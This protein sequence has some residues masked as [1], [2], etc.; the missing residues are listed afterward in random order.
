MGL[1]PPQIKAAEMLAKGHSQQATG[2]AVGVSRRTILRWL[3]Q[4]DFKNLSYG[5]VGRAVQ[6]PQ[7]SPQRFPERR[8]QSGSLTPEDL[9]EDALSAVQSIL[10]DPEVRTCDRLKAASLIGEWAGLS[11]RKPP[12]HEMEGLEAMIKAGWVPDEVLDALIESSNDMQER[13]RNAFHNCFEKG[14]KKSL[15]QEV[16]PERGTVDVDFDDDEDE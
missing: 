11:H 12:M 7:P 9:I 3:K 4:E 16:N 14:N 13:V 1:T 2:E 5:L 8:R 10:I 6:S 15:S